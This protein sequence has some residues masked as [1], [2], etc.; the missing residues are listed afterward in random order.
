MDIK[1]IEEEIKEKSAQLLPFKN[2]EPINP[3]RSPSKKQVLRKK[4]KSTHSEDQSLP[5]SL[6]DQSSATTSTPG[7]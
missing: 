2:S 5:A 3:E 6:I 1:N 7:E 4:D